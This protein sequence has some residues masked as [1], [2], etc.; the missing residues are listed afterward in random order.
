MKNYILTFS[1]MILMLMLG[2]SIYHYSFDY[3]VGIIDSGRLISEYKGT[4]AALSE[5]ETKTKVWKSNLDTLTIE[6]Q[7]EI[8]KFE[9]DRVNMSE[10]EIQLSHELLRN[11][12][13][14]VEQYQQ[15]TENKIAEEDKK[16]S[17]SVYAYINQVVS[18]Y[19]KKNNFKFI[20]GAKGDGGVLY[21]DEAI[22]ITN[23]LIEILN[24]TEE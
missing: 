11:K 14:Q 4:K 16:V 9:K 24:D 20:L 10:K 22:D 17:Q 15:V 13:S 7:N 21:G 18:A 12:Q 5:L 8:K 23:E 2:F 6:F 3:K 1:T 19:G